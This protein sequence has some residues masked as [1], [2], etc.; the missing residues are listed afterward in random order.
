MIPLPPV[1]PRMQGLRTALDGDA[2]APV[3]ENT[4]GEVTMRECN[5]YY[6]RYKPG[7]YARVQYRLDFVD[8]HGAHVRAAAHIAIYPPARAERLA[9][10][11]CPVDRGG[12]DL[13]S[14]AIYLRPLHGIAQVF[15]V[16]FALP[17]LQQAAA[18]ETITRLFSRNFSDVLS[19]DFR[20]CEVELVRYKAGKRAVL[21]Y[22]LDGTSAS[23]VYGKLR[24]DG[25]ESVIKSGTA[26]RRAGAPTPET[27]GWLPDIGMAVQTEAA[28]VRLADLRHTEQYAQWMPAVADTLARLHAVRVDGLPRWSAQAEA[29]ELLGAAGTV[30]TLLPHIGGHAASLARRVASILATLDRDL[31]TTH[32]S[33]HDDQVLVGETGVTLIDMD[34]AVLG[35]PLSDV[36]HFLSYLPVEHAGDAYDR[37]LDRYLS[38][39][40]SG[41]GEH[42]VF[43]AASLLRW[44]TMP[45]R[46]Q[47]PDWPEAV[48]ERVRRSAMLLRS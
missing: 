25:A 44:A 26:L 31:T 18:P 4:L 20:G 27:I 13:R 40:P 11:H 28:G 41:G 45:F 35:N 43:E 32:G 2:M 39:R 30:A 6:A 46:E 21:K 12:S 3:F 7:R 48:E 16:D 5:P 15:P 24:K 9:A 14:R 33:F 29:A 47:R 37:F 42:L 8:A 23:V 22:H 17:G 36:G 19:L 34:S 1:D 10:R 38:A